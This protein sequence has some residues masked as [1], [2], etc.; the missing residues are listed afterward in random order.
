M[1]FKL[2]VPSTCTAYDYM[3]CTQDFESELQAYIKPFSVD[4]VTKILDD[5]A[6]FQIDATL[7]HCLFAIQP[8]ETFSSLSIKFPSQHIFDKFIAVLE[9]KVTHAA[10][11]LFEVCN[12]NHTIKA[13][14]GQLLNAI[15]CDVFTQCL[16][17]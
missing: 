9:P 11:M 4:N 12:C 15:T 17:S 7:P 5:L 2:Y 13:L 8:G 3:S 10:Q 6:S 1:F 14:A 16:P